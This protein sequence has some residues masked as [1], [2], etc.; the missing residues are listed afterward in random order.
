MDGSADGMVKRWIGWIDEWIMDGGMID[1]M[2]ELIDWWM[3]G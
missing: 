2:D 3:D 1:W